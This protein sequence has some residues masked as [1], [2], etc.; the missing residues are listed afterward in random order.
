MEAFERRRCRQAL[1]EAHLGIGDSEGAVTHYDASEIGLTE[2]VDDA[3][4]MSL[5]ADQRVI[6]VTSA[7]AVLPRSS[8]A[9]NADEE[10]GGDDDAPASAGSE[11]V[12]Q[13]YVKAPTPGVSLLFEA[14]RFD[15]EGEDKRKSDRVRKFYA[16]IP[17][18]VEFKRF[19][20]D[21]ARVQLFALAKQRNVKIDAAAAAM[22]V[23]SLGADV[24]RIAI[25]LDK[26]SL[27]AMDGRAITMDD[28]VELIPDA[29]TSTVFTLVN[30][31]GRGDRSRALASLDALCRENEYL[32][33]ALAFLSTQF[34]QALAARKAGLR[35]SQQ[36]QTYFTKAGVNMWGSRQSRW[37]KPLKSSVRPSW[38]Q[39]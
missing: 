11:S 18:V 35:S 24:A 22:L 16:A 27:Y 33:L 20:A 23:D 39:G 9:S 13:S 17:D 6:L 34:R 2:I 38:N 7:E 32:P 14:S 31:L 26:L 37:L 1:I 5:F 28:I 10:T 8:R 12:L 4:A 15:L 29:R 36:V 30:A 21:D 19:S 3:R 25:E